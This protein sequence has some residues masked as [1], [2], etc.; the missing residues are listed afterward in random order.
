[1]EVR[2]NSTEHEERVAPV[3]KMSNVS[4]TPNGDGGSIVSGVHW[5]YT[6]GRRVVV[7]SAELE[8]LSKSAKTAWSSSSN[9]YEVAEWNIASSRESGVAHVDIARYSTRLVAASVVYSHD[10]ST[11]RSKLCDMSCIYV[12]SGV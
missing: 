4:N 1:M 3:V 11:S 7:E 9:E 12:S 6:N 10:A 2:N 8:S 5:S